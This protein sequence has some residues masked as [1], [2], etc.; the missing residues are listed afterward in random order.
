MSTDLIE[1]AKRIEANTVCQDEVIGALK[2]GK[3]VS[4]FGSK[5]FGERLDYS[6]ETPEIRIQSS[7]GSSV[8]AG[9]WS[10]S[11]MKINNS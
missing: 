1:R 11:S 3:E 5:V 8:P 2:S 7:N 10:F 9:F 4:L 6:W